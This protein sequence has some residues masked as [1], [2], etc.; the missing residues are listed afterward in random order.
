[1][2][3]NHPPLLGYADRLSARAGE[4]VEVK[5]SSYLEG[6]YTARLVRTIC[7]DPNP[8][9]MGLTEE[10]V[11]SSFASTY[12]ARIQKFAPGSC[13]KVPLS[14]SNSLPDVFTASAMI[15][16][17][18]LGREKQAVLSVGL[19][20]SGTAFIL[21]LDATG[22]PW[23]AIKLVD[24]SWAECTLPTPLDERQWAHLS[25]RRRR[26]QR[27]RRL[28]KTANYVHFYVFL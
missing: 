17:T 27:R 6:E 8:Q 16:P 14:A 26:R 21:G 23:A 10:D 12:P 13:V 25:V 28:L 5:V 3:H 20:N 2:T 19:A 24:G 1:M 22:R 4:I 9:G 18:L 7:A 11:D 15:W